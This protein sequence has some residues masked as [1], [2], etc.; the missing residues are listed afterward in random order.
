MEFGGEQNYYARYLGEEW[1]LSCHGARR[2]YIDMRELSLG[3]ELPF[4][5]GYGGGGG[6]YQEDDELG[7]FLFLSGGVLGEHASVGIGAGAGM[8]NGPYIPVWGGA[9]GFQ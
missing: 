6:S 9:I 4:L 1:T 5:G 8:S 2:E 3:I 7:Y